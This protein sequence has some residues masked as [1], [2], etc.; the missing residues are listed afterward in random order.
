MYISDNEQDTGY[1]NYPKPEIIRQ[2]SDNNMILKCTATS[3]LYLKQNSVWEFK[4]CQPDFKKV[5]CSSYYDVNKGYL[6]KNVSWDPVTGHVVRHK[7]SV[8]LHL[9]KINTSFSGLYRCINDDKVIKIYE[10]IV[11]DSLNK[12]NYQPPELLDVVPLNATI[13]PNMQMIIQCRVYSQRL[14]VIWWFKESDETNYDIKYSGKYYLQINTSIQAYGIP[15]ES[16]V[17]L[18]KLYIHR[19]QEQD[20][21][22]YV[23]FAMTETGMA[24]KDASIKVIT[25][26]KYWKSDSS[27]VLLFLIPITFALIPITIWLCYYRK[28]KKCVKIS[29]PRYTNGDAVRPILMQRVIISDRII[30]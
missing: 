19:A 11:V 25:S 3:C 20:S 28:K 13:A 8:N 27:F 2:Q 29:S 21:G 7:C 26:D 18:S 4:A 23:C 9:Q 5:S 16:N 6:T 10:I 12:Y 14:P 1:S 24:H 30:I 22:K 15:Q 17:Y